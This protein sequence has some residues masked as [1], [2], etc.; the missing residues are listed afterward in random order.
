MPG[1][2]NNSTHPSSLDASHPVVGAA[3]HL[4]C[5]ISLVVLQGS[6]IYLYGRRYHHNAQQNPHSFTCSLP[7]AP[8]PFTF[9]VLPA[10]ALASQKRTESKKRPATLVQ[11]LGWLQLHREHL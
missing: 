3:R 2:Q 6:S 5:V 8:L 9:P 11:A 7:L 4:A 1:G 10:L